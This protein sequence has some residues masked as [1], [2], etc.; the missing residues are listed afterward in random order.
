M[1]NDPSEPRFVKKDAAPIE[2]N[3]IPELWQRDRRR[4]KPLYLTDTRLDSIVGW[5]CVAFAVVATL[6]WLIPQLLMRD[7]P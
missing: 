2:R 6:G 7:T 5:V 3:H 4:L 1:S